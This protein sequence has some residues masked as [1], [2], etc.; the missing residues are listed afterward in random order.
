MTAASMRRCDYCHTT[1]PADQAFTPVF[2]GVYSRCKD[3][4]ACNRRQTRAYDPTILADEDMPVRLPAVSGATCSLCRTF[5]PPGGA[6]A[7]AAGYACRD[8]AGCEQRQGL[9]LAPWTD[10][11]PDQLIAQSGGHLR[12]PASPPAV[13]PAVQPELS[14]DEIAALAAADALGRKRR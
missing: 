13:V 14:H 3:E 6:D 2:G 11:S 1:V 4:R 5:D 9:D 10:S 8:R 7:L 12:M